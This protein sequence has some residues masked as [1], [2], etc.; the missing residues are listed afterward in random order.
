MPLR[1][2]SIPKQTR[3]Y[4]AKAQ[5]ALT[6]ILTETGTATLPSWQIFFPSF[7][8]FAHL[9]VRARRVGLRFRTRFYLFQIP[10]HLLILVQELL[11]S[12]SVGDEV[13]NPM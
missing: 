4:P 12:M 3:C 6:E 8:F 10:N 9:E 2:R 13:E 1:H 7:C 5:Q 11:R